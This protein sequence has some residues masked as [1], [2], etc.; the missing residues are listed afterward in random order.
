M[1]RG[2]ERKIILGIKTT[3]VDKGTE[4]RGQGRKPVGGAVGHPAVVWWGQDPT[5]GTV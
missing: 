1:Q 2:G 5:L 3:Q 4:V